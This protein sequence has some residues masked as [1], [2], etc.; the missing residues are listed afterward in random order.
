VKDGGKA[1]TKVTANREAIKN[2]YS[3][4]LSAQRRAK[5]SGLSGIK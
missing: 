5:H 2:I 3:Q 1:E 4:N